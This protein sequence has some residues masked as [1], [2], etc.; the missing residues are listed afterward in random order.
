[1]R[2]TSATDRFTSAEVKRRLT[3]TK[4][5]LQ[6]YNT[7]RLLFLAPKDHLMLPCIHLEGYDCLNDYNFV[8]TVDLTE[9]MIRDCVKDNR[10]MFVDES[11]F[12]IYSL[13]DYVDEYSDA[14]KRLFCV[15]S[16]CLLD[17]N[18]NFMMKIIVCLGSLHHAPR[19]FYKDA[20]NRFYYDKLVAYDDLF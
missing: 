15:T 14:L 6:R 13:Q 18:K 11:L 19:L 17:R 2:R 1:M 10:E 5:Y 4:R 9:Q 7:Q 12:K 8:S 3:E 16:F 20:K